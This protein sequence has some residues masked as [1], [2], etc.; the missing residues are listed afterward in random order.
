LTL[1]KIEWV[2]LTRIEQD[3]DRALALADD[4]H[5]LKHGRLGLSA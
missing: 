5:V 4:A 1:L 2:T 3:I